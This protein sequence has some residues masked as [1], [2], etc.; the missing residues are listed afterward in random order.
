LWCWRQVAAAL[1]RS[2][3]SD[4]PRCRSDSVRQI[5]RAAGVSRQATKT[6]KASKDPDFVAK[7]NRILGLCDYPHADGRTAC[8]DEVGQVNLRP[9]PG[10]GWVP[11][12]LHGA[13]KRL[14]CPCACGMDRRCEV[15]RLSDEHRNDDDLFVPDSLEAADVIQR[16]LTEYM[17][18]VGN[19][20]IAKGLNQDGEPSSSE[21]RRD[22]NRHR[23]AGGWQ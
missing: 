16:I 12:A 6:W 8:V 5:P 23:L 2:A 17:E 15:V 11:P 1:E 13:T 4:L 9:R 7:K 20:A 22:Q 14:A 21:R 3:R 19:R 10:R 18:G